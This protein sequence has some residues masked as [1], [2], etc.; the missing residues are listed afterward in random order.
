M[1]YET[2]LTRL[3]G[4]RYPLIQAPMAG[5]PTTP[6]LVAAVS[7]AGG[8]GSFGAAYLAPGAIRTAI[9]AIR[10][11]TD[12][13]FNMNLFA[14]LPEQAPPGTLA[15]AQ[16]R[17]DAYREDLGIPSSAI[18]SGPFG[19]PF[20]EAIAVLVEERVPVFSFTFGLLPENALQRIKACG[21][22]V[23]GTAT[24]VAEGVALEASGVDAV[25]AQG[26]EAGG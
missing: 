2:S 14:P 18:P 22:T 9:R 17:L 8:L 11:R 10:E 24:T 19:P 23:I 15:R 26:S 13:P 7:N 3:V 1:K 5:G 4:I 12:R 25:V 6:E 21:A 20:A 16:A